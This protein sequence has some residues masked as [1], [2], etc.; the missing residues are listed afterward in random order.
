MNLN[1]IQTKVKTLILLLSNTKNCETLID[2]THTKPQETLEFKKTK[3]REKFH[4]NPPFQSTAD[5]MIGL[6]VLEI[7]RSF[8][9]ITEENNNIELEVEFSYTQLKDKVAEV[10]GLS[11]ITTEKLKHETFG[12]KKTKT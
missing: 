12:P 9:S 7:Y 10:L 8:L 11:D 1:M 5:W 2:Q 3:S 4:F 6:V